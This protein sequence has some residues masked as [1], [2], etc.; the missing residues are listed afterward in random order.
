MSTAPVVVTDDSAVEKQ[1]DDRRPRSWWH[2]PAT[3]TVM[4]LI[5]LVQIGRAHV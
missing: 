2:L 5:A 3:T 4:A 1:L